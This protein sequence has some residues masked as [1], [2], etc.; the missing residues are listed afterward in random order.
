[1]LD[2][3][4]PNGQWT[5]GTLSTDPVVTSPID[6]SSFTNGVYNFT[7]T[8]NLLPNPCAEESTTVQVIILQDPNAGVAVNQTFC[9][10][11]LT[12]NSPFDLFQPK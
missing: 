9:E 10:N 1:M 7:Y 11:D 6:L 4:D 5:Q 3:E 12:G 8:Q 2:N